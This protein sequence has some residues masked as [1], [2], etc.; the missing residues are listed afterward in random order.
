[1]NSATDGSDNGE[2]QVLNELGVPRYECDSDDDRPPTWTQREYAAGT[3]LVRLYA[4]R[5]GGWEAAATAELT[6]QVPSNQRPGAPFGQYPENRSYFGTKTIHFDWADTYRTTNY[7]LEAA[8]DS[9]YSN[10]VLDVTLPVGQSEYTHTFAQEHEIIYWRVTATG[11]YGSD[12]STK[13]FHIDMTPPDSAVTA[14]SAT[15]V[16]NKFT[17]RWGG[18]DAR[19]GLRWYD[20]QVRDGNRSDSAWE[21]WLVNT[22]TTAALFAGQP[23]HTYYFRSRAMDEIGNWEPWPTLADGDTHTRIDPSSAPPVVWWDDDYDENVM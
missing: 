22:D 18:S 19:S 17:V 11:P 4:R 5:D 2:W 14:L 7:R 13:E 21:D 6:I 23:G 20:V 9:G 16:E 8:T 10:K 12:A 1:M 15:T 3:H